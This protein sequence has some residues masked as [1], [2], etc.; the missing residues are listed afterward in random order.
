MN[1]RTAT[2]IALA[3]VVAGGA[4]AQ[5]AT[6]VRPKPKPKPIVKEYTV[7]ATPYP[8]AAATAACD[9]PL[10]GTFHRETIKPTGP[11]VLTVEVTNFYGDWDTGVFNAGG[12]LLREGSGT[13]ADDPQPEKGVEKL[14]YTSRKAQ[15]LHID[16]CNFAGTPTADVKLVYTYS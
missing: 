5:A 12:S 6:K 13:A 10:E 2:T 7:T 16:V 15:T 4:N 1:A 14:I 8:N 3:V 9:E 11:G